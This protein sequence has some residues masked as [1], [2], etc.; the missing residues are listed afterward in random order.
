MC[1]R[2]CTR[3]DRVFVSYR[4]QAFRDALLC[5]V[6]FAWLLL[7]YETSG[8]VIGA[9]SWYNVTTTNTCMHT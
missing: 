2:R 7:P 1:K 8:Y 5:F 3:F 4:S 6:A 9:D